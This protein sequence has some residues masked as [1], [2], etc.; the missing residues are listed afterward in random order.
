MYVTTHWPCEA[1]SE[2]RWLYESVPLARGGWFRQ[3]R[4]VNGKREKA[5][6][7]L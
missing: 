1:R 6:G 2:V 5:V 7:A 3:Q 4:Q